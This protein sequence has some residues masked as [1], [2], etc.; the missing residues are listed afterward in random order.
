MS[1]GLDISGT[2]GISDSWYDEARLHAWMTEES[3]N[4]FQRYRKT[5]G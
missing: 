4:G 2:E 3:L 5:E 1:F